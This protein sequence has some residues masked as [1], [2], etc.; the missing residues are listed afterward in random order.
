M[1]H[2]I[3]LHG[4]CTWRAASVAVEERFDHP[5]VCANLQANTFRTVYEPLF[6]QHQVDLVFAGHTHA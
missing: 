2:R 4:A 3:C 5:Y 6:Y 1:A